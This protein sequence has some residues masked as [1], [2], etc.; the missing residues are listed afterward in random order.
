MS[1]AQPPHPPWQPE[2]GAGRPPALPAPGELQRRAPGQVQKLPVPPKPPGHRGRVVAITLAVVL[3]VLTVVGIGGLG[4]G[5][6]YYQRA[7]TPDRRTP[8]VVVEQ[9]V[10]ATFNERDADRA[11]IFTC[12]TSNLSEL[13]GMVSD[14]EAREGQFNTRFNVQTADLNVTTNKKTAAVD[15]DLQISTPVSRSTQRWRFALKNES[16]WRVCGAQR[17]A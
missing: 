8:A 17:V 9:F 7:A 6:F 15:T 1:D 14:L 12:R 11:K 10:E 3:G 4:L 5:Y 2:H 13:H 16:G